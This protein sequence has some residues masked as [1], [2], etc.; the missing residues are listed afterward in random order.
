MVD[1][2]ALLAEFGG[3]PG[4]SVGAVRFPVYGP[5]PGSELGVGRLPGGPVRGRPAPVVEAGAGDA[6]DAA[7][8]LHAE[9]TLVV[10]DE[11]EAVHQRVSPAKYFAAFRRISR[12]SSNSRTFLRRA[13]FSASSGVAGSVETSARRPRT[14]LAPAPRTPV[15]QGPRVTPRAAANAP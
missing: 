1:A 10:G 9:T 15:P 7:Q 11:L 4:D 6:E 13:A 14:R 12:S 5:Y 2:F 3:D 8:P